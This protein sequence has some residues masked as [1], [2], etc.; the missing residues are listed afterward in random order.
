MLFLTVVP[1]IRWTDRWTNIDR[2]LMTASVVF[3]GSLCL[4]RLRCIPIVLVIVI[5]PVLFLPQT[6]SLIVLWLLT[7]TTVLC[8][9]K[10]RWIA[11]TLCRCIGIVLLMWISTVLT[12][13][14][15]VN[16][17][18][19][20]IR[21]CRSFL[22]TWLLDMPMPLVC[23]W[24][25]ILEMLR[26]SRVRCRRLTLIRT[27]LL[28]LLLIPI[29]VMLGIGL[30]CCPRLLL[31]KWWSRPSLVLLV[32]VFEFEFE[33]FSWTTGLA[34]GP[35]CSSMG[36]CV[37]SG[38]ASILSWLC[39]LRSVWLTLAFY[40][41]LRTMLSRLVCDMDCIPCMPVMMLSVLLIGRASRPLTL[42]G[43][44]LASLA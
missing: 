42:V 10:F 22:L 37:L 16:R 13:L 15:A 4:T 1:C 7:W 20:C 30:S 38:S 33:S 9:W 23:R 44:V 43:V 18:T 36:P 6:V 40:V 35:K 11:V 21:K 25:T 14:M 12:L 17:P 2:L 34:D 27:L 8:L 26:P 3:R 31:V 39:M 5:A 29:V 24:V 41:N 32:L 28:R 19:A